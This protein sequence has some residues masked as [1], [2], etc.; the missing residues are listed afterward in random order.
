MAQAAEFRLPLI[1]KTEPLGPGVTLHH[2]KALKKAD[3][4]D[5]QVLTVELKKSASAPTC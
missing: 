3:W 5:Q 2:I 1:N 4:Y